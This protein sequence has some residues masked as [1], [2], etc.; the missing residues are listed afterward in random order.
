MLF[1]EMKKLTTRLTVRAA[2][3]LLC[4][5]LPGQA[6]HLSTR[7]FVST[8]RLPRLARCI[9]HS[10]NKHGIPPV[11][12]TE[13]TA[14]ALVSLRNLRISELRE[15]ASVPESAPAPTN[16]LYSLRVLVT[17]TV[18]GKEEMTVTAVFFVRPAQIERTRPPYPMGLTGPSNWRPIKSKG[19]LEKRWNEI[20][21]SEC[22]RPQGVSDR[23]PPVELHFAAR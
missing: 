19:V 21:H 9:E 15:L 2:P 6:Y 10:M 11:R 20:I 18:T 22:L 4:T 1:N 7:D 14:I 23:I 8:T 5:I 13:G 17:P 3:F 12:R 16:G